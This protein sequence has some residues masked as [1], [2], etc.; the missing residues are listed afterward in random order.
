MIDI[1]FLNK[2]V[3]KCHKANPDYDSQKLLDEVIRH[4]CK[5]KAPT[6]YQRNEAETIVNE[7]IQNMVCD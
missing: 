5:T 1:E 3:L 6:N 2:L 4:Y 7:M